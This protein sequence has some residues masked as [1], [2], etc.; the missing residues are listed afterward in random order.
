MNKGGIEF[1]IAFIATVTVTRVPRSPEVKAPTCLIPF[2]VTILLGFCTVV[3]PV[4]STLYISL[5][6]KW[7]LS[8]T[9]CK[10]SKNTL[11]YAA[12]KLVALE[13]LVGWAHL[14]DNS[15]CLFINEVNQSSPTKPFIFHWRGLFISYLA[16]NSYANFEFLWVGIHSKFLRRYNTIYHRMF[17]FRAEDPIVT[18]VSALF[19]FWIALFFLAYLMRDTWHRSYFLQQRG[20]TKQS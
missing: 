15:L 16:T 18:V 8:K 11:T 12:L 2:L 7:S 14:I 5:A 4:S 20:Q 10:L 1:P 17:L 19:S 13:R 6:T 3:T 9:F